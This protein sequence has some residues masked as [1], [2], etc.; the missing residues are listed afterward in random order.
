MAKIT[1]TADI[2]E[3]NRYSFMV[4]V[5]DNLTEDQ[6]DEQGKAKL[7]EFLD[8]NCPYPFQREAVNGVICDDRESAMRTEDVVS[9]EVNQK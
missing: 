8:K 4:E 9:I 1:M 7:K 3:I 6:Q 5:D 2:R